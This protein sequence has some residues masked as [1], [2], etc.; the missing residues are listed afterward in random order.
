MYDEL[1]EGTVRRV[2][3]ISECLNM[4]EDS[5]VCKITTLMNIILKR[6]M[7]TQRTVGVLNS[8]YLE[9]TSQGPV[10]PRLLH[11]DQNTWEVATL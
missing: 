10:I 4:L 9:F 11:D 2:C 3:I 7:H 5:S 1:L 6:P 8:T